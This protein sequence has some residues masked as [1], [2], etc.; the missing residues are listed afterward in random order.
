MN[1]TS[2]GEERRTPAD[3]VWEGLKQSAHNFCERLDIEI[4]A[5]QLREARLQRTLD[6]V[7]AEI[8]HLKEEGVL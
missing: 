5:A 4:E 6:T 1:Q 3:E 7:R 2:N 8:K